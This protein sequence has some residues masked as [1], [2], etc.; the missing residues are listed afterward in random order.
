MV[1]VL[2]GDEVQEILE[3]CRETGV[4]SDYT[5]G[6]EQFCELPSHLGHGY[7]R[8]LQLRPRL[9]LSIADLEKHQTHIHKIQH[10]QT[11]PLT[12]S[13]YLSGGCVVDNDGLTSS[14]EEVAGKSYLYCLPNTAEIE[15]YPAKKRIQRVSFQISSE[16]LQTFDD[17]LYELPIDIRQAVEQPEKA[18]LHCPSS[19]TP[20]QR[21]ILQQIFRC[22]FQGL[23]RQIYLE[24]KVLELLALQL[25]QLNAAPKSNKLPADDID[26]IY[27][28]RDILI[29]N[30]TQPPSLAELAR[31]VQLN[32][33]KLKQ[34]FRQVFKTT[35]FGYLY[36]YR[37]DQAQQLLQTG[38]LNIQETAR[39]VGYASRS[40]FVAAFKKK[41]Q[42]PPSHFQ[43]S[44]W[45]DQ[46]LLCSKAERAR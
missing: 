36:N 44:G 29:G 43:K 11:M 10:P 27:H 33:R 6:T 21:Q 38:Q 2:T 40:S 7:W 26:R 18:K 23:T 5:E 31:K 3:E 17:R 13:F 22:P 12:L 35:V 14:I 25:E 8:S 24:A 15:N 9:Q 19:I 46:S 45:E 41:F 20:I 39:C 4:V 42:V 1:N 30:V 32:E 16:L 37:M 34:G 28:A